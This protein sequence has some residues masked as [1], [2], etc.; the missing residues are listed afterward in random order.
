M[1]GPVNLASLNHEE[2]AFLVGIQAG[3]R[4]IRHFFQRRGLCT[5]VDG[6]VESARGEQPKNLLVLVF[7]QF[8]AGCNEAVSVFF[9]QIRKILILAY[10]IVQS[11]AKQNVNLVFAVNFLI[12]IVIRNRIHILAADIVSPECGRC[13]MCNL[14]GSYETCRFALFL[15]FFKYGLHFGM[16]IIY[17]DGGIVGLDPG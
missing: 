11:T 14:G 3:N 7:Q 2:E 10:K 5:P 1:T 6:F 16:I 4:R 13:C 9:E 8:V 15:G 17:R 12:I